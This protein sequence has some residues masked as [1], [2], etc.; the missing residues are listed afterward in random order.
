MALKT[1][2]D[3][4]QLTVYLEGRLDRNAA[5]ELQEELEPM[6]PG[7]GRLLLDF[8][9]VDYVSS[10]GLRAL[11]KLRQTM[12]DQQGQMT[13][14]HINELVMDVFDVT[15]FLEILEIV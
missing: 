2:R 4:D 7:V 1:H 10:A 8:Q 13:L 14:C 9:N 6:L 12:E 15:G 3:G 5:P 11:L